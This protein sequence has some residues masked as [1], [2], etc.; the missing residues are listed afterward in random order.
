MRGVVVHKDT[1]IVVRET[2]AHQSACK[3]ALRCGSLSATW[4]RVA[5]WKKVIAAFVAT[6]KGFAVGSSL[7]V[8]VEAD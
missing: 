6:K 1:G 7:F 4:V 3:S 5:R 2:V 8:G